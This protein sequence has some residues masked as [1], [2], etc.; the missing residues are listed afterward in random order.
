MHG[1]YRGYDGVTTACDEE[2]W[3][4]E[5]RDRHEVRGLGIHGAA[6]QVR[7]ERTKSSCCSRTGRYHRSTV[8][9]YREEWEGKVAYG[10]YM[11][12]ADL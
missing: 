5:G 4:M 11:S 3:R 9:A 10:R 2:L 7:L 12:D 6:I 1:R 8:N